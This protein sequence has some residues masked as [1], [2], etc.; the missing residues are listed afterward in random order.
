MY[1]AGI[2]ADATGSVTVSVFF[3]AACPITFFAGTFLLPETG[4]LSEK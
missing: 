3:A 4:A 1:T 2:I